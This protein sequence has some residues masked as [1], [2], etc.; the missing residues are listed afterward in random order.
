MFYSFTF[1]ALLGQAALI[2]SQK[3]SRLAPEGFESSN[4]SQPVTDPTTHKHIWSEPASFLTRTAV[5]Y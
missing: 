1:Y 2:S 5:C 4:K 3:R